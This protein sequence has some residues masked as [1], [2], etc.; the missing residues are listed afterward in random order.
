MGVVIPNRNLAVR[1][2]LAG[3][4]GHGDRTAA[5]FAPAGAAYPAN[6]TANGNTPLGTP[7][8]RTWSI[9]LDP[10]LWPVRQ[11]DMIVDPD[12]GQQWQ[13]TSAQLTDHPLFPTVSYIQ[14]QAH[15]Y[16]TGTRA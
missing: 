6:A 3:A 10:R 5:G 2:R 1:A 12:T 8:G 9:A 13:V 15:E 16:T 11:Q 7:G 14:V 4:D